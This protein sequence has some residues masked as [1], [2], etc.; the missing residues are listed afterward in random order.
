[1]SEKDEK[2]CE[3]VLP[4]A[5]LRLY[6]QAKRRLHI[7]AGDIAGVIRALDHLWPG[8]GSCLMDSRPAVRRHISIMIEGER[9]QLETVV[10]QGA[11]VF[12]LTAVSGG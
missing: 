10:P 12:I 5:L 2:A 3:V 1:M 7:A 9:A 4:D 8:M 11:T 6:P